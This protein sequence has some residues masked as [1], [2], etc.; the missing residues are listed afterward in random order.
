[1][2]REDSSQIPPCID[3]ELLYGV[4]MCS[5]DD[6]GEAAPIGEAV[7]QNDHQTSFLHFSFFKVAQFGP[8]WIVA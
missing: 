5:G 4:Q 3:T 2:V 1:M 6:R 7:M 8:F